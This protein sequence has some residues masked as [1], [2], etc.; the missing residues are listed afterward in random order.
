MP[1]NAGISKIELEEEFGAVLK[2]VASEAEHA[3]TAVDKYGRAA[4][5]AH[6]IYER[7]GVLPTASSPRHGQLRRQE[8]KIGSVALQPSIGDVITPGNVNMVAAGGADL[9][10]E[11]PGYRRFGQAGSGV[12]SVAG[13]LIVAHKYLGGNTQ[14][15]FPTILKGIDRTN[16]A[17]TVV[18]SAATLSNLLPDCPEQRNHDPHLIV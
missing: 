14:Q 8:E 7:P 1:L 18:N 11:I 5:R 17:L 4:R 13:S 2:N 16:D 10:K 3:A 6:R 12:T 9:V 15:E